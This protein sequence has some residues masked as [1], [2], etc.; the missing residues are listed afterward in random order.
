MNLEMLQEENSRLK[1]EIELLQRRNSLLEGFKDDILGL[2]PDDS[3]CK[4][5]VTGYSIVDDLKDLLK[6]QKPRFKFTSDDDGHDYII[7]VDKQNE[8]EEYLDLIY[9]KNEYPEHPIWAIQVNPSCVTFENWKE[10]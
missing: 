5:E 8:W 6:K 7:P 10:K 3:P 1:F 9:N 2:L 4:H